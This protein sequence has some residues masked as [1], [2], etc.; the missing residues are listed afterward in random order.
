MWAGHYRRLLM[1]HGMEYGGTKGGMK[2]HS[3][4]PNQGKNCDPEMYG[5]V[6]EKEP[7]PSSTQGQA[8]DDP[9]HNPAM[10]ADNAFHHRPAPS[11]KPDNLTGDIESAGPNKSEG[12][13]GIL[14]Y[15][16]AGPPKRTWKA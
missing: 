15:P 2:S 1:K 4:H 11:A 14:E 8:S 5:G 13:T 6:G 16:H 10:A 3:Y 12:D 9:P 7:R